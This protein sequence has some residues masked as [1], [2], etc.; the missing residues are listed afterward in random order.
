MREGWPSK[1]RSKPVTFSH[2]EMHA[3]LEVNIPNYAG[4]LVTTD[5]IVDS[6]C[7]LNIRPY[8]SKSKADYE[9]HTPHLRCG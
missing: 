6:I 2:K 9:D 5:K 4:S 7:S 8:R 1:M 3:A